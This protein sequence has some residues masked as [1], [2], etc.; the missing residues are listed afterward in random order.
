MGTYFKKMGLKSKN[1]KQITGFFVH[2]KN[3]D[4]NLK[5]GNLCKCQIK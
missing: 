5:A 4:M 3:G 1:I 2:P